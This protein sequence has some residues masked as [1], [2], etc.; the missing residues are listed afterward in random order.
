MNN[1]KRLAQLARERDKAIRYLNDWK[2]KLAGIDAE[3]DRL[4]ALV[5]TQQIAEVN[6]L[7]SERRRKA[8]Y[9]EWKRRDA[10]GFYS[11]QMATGAARR[12]QALACLGWSIAEVGR[13]MGKPTMAA[14]IIKRERLGRRINRQTYNDV[15]AVYDRLSVR[16]PA[17]SD[18]SAKLSIARAKRVALENGWA[19][20]MAWDDIDSD[21]EPRGMRKGA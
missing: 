19:P 8:A 4:E 9:I 17:P 15:C 7:R 11:R 5:T 14:A 20:P 2:A 3:I 12:I 10:E 21:L 16:I 6:R 13:Q 18:T 1:A